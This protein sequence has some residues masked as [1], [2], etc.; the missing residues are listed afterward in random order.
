MNIN[1]DNSFIVLCFK[2]EKLY[3]QLSI[4]GRKQSFAWTFGAYSWTYVKHIHGNAKC[5]AVV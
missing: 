4:I 5:S 1:S 2:I 3:K